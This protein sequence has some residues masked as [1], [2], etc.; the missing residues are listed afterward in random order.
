MEIKLFDKIKSTQTYLIEQIY[1]G[2]VTDELAVLALEQSDGVGSRNNKWSSSRGNFFA[3]IA[4]KEN[5]ISRDL[6]M[7]SRSIYFA[8][9]MREVLCS[10]GIDVWLKWPNDLYFGEDKVGGVIT[11][12]LDAFIVVGIGINMGDKNH[13][14]A[15]LNIKTEPEQL[16]EIFL[17]EVAKKPTWKKVFSQYKIEFELSKSY[18]THMKEVKI[19]MKNAILCKDGSLS[20]DG[21]RVYGLR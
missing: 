12:Q 2:T 17:V 9:L 16:L 13:N 21:E 14:F 20:I 11:R 10:F 18:F 6:P 3:S 19:D 15:G 5:S 1:N 7:A 8:F 4:I